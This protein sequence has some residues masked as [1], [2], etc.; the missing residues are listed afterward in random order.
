MDRKSLLIVDDEENVRRALERALRGEGY[1]LRFAASGR[2]AL[3]LMRQEPADMV[4]SDH[5]MPTMTGLE[6][7]REVRKLHPD[8]LRII[9][10]G[11]ADLEMAI[12]AINEGEI[13]RFLTK[14]WD[15]VE[16]QVTV[17]LGFERLLLERENRRLLATVKRQSDYIRSL[18]TE[19]PG[20]STVQRDAAGTV[21]IDDEEMVRQF[22][23]TLGVRAA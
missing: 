18:E 14:P 4:I 8:S 23:L 13:Y 6:L 12:S 15:Q 11:Y 19:Y 5:M 10:T 7:M 20:I 1:T 3:D 9:L 2:E 22:G 16:L 17:R 21:V